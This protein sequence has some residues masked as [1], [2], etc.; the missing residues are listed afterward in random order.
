MCVPL[1]SLLPKNHWAGG[2]RISLEREAHRK[3][4]EQ[5]ANGY[6]SSSG[7][8]RSGLC[9]ISQKLMQKGRDLFE[10]RGFV[11]EIICASGE[12]FIAI[13]GIRIVRA[14][15]YV[16]AGMVWTNRTENVETRASGHLEIEDHGVRF[17]LLDAANR[18][19]HVACLSSNL[20]ARDVPQELGQTL[21]EQ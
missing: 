18:F 1:L 4:D 10:F 13:L 2:T 8:C 14:N 19:R 17:H 21:D 15:Q 9:P 12:A 16:E 11:E 3:R 5:F 20:D 6:E 7:S